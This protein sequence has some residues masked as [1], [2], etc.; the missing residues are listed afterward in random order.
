MNGLDQG[1]VLQ[2]LICPTEILQSLPVQK[3]HLAHCTRRCHEPRNVVNDLTPG[4]FSCT[5]DLLPPLA[6]LDVCAGSVPSK[7]VARFIPQWIAANQE[8]SIGTVESTNARLRVDRNSRS[9]RRLPLL[10]KSFP[11]VGMNCLRPPP[12]LRLFGGHVGI[13]KPHLIEEVTVAIGA[14]SPY[15]C[16]DRIDY[17]TQFGF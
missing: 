16:G 1:P 10:D 6:I 5:Q 2:F 15:C 17:L 7:D 9:E 8:R 3:L 12:A 4:E 11:V 14:S 13:L